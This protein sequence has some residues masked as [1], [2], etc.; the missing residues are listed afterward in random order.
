[1][2][3]LKFADGSKNDIP[4]EELQKIPYFK[5]LPD[6]KD[7]NKE[8]NLSFNENFTYNNII[9]CI[10]LSE[11]L[12][13]SCEELMNYFCIESCYYSKNYINQLHELD[14]KKA[15]ENKNYDA[16]IAKCHIE[17]YYLEY[18]VK[19]INKLP[20]AIIEKCITPYNTKN[21]ELALSCQDNHINLTKVLIN[22]NIDIERRYK[23]NLTLI[24][25]AS[26][27]GN[28]EIV[29]ILIKAGANVNALSNKFSYND[30][31]D[32]FGNFTTYNYGY[33]ALMVASKNG[34]KEIVEL[35]VNAGAD[36]NFKNN[37]HETALMFACQKKDNIEIVKILV[38]AGA[39]V[40]DFDDIGI[41]YNSTVLNKA[42]E[43]NNLDIA[44][45]LVKKGA[46]YNP[47][48]PNENVRKFF[49]TI[50]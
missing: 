33:T 46:T 17:R 24:I 1:M 18:N 12:T 43:Y 5:N 28:K 45:Y 23:Y 25:I 7:D 32:I 4:L 39:N 11:P 14:L 41:T 48:F 10:A 19:E 36:V 50:A 27:K 37:L 6:L 29:E 38:N 22:N 16:I 20:I 21:N 40:N 34:H 9:R 26:S 44:K 42:I 47:D 35:L 2:V 31:N 15:I 30:N 3:L 49:E 8:L 13:K